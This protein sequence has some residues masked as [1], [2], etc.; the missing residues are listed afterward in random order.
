MP[1]ASKIAR[2]CV[3][4]FEAFFWAFLDVINPP[5]KS[6]L[7]IYDE[8]KKKSLTGGKAARSNPVW[9]PARILR[10]K[11]KPGNQEDYA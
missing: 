10:I 7:D 3:D 6:F 5:N 4:Q 11:S 9:T 1:K 8:L 2:F